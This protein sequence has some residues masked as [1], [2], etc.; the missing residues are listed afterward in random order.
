MNM[1]LTTHSLL[2]LAVLLA[3]CGAPPAATELPA[4]EVDLVAAPT[5]T[6]D[7]SITLND[8]LNRVVTL[9]APAQRVISLAPSNTEILFAIGAGDQVVGRDDPS[10]FPEQATAIPSVGDTF[11]GLNTETI[12]NL[13]PD[14][15]LAAEITPVEYITE[16]EQL[17]ITVFW[18]ANP[19]TL[20]GLYINLGIVGQ[21]TGHVN[22]ADALVQTMQSR[23]IAVRDALADVTEKP[24]VFYEL[25]ASDPNA[26]WTSGA[27]TFIDILITEAGG[28][29]AGSV[30][31]GEFA[32]MS[33][34][35]LLVQ[36]PDVIL[37]GDAAYGVTVESVGLRAGWGQLAAVQN[38]QVY[39][40]NDSLVSRPGP[41]LIDALE[42]LAV[43]LH[44]DQF[45]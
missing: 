4:P 10:D 7:L 45:N 9:A 12:V 33:I 30:V 14:L 38:G 43:L 27:G 35:D 17:G 41:R 23:V 2:L 26:P 16:L 20:E 13:Q 24:T 21:L 6:A 1:K 37:L 25:D 39:P 11:A 32:Q 18:M 15:V 22:E 19:D 3:A 44:P 34:E 29:N 5:D 28:Q 42:Q 8:G 36:N 31:T 40:F